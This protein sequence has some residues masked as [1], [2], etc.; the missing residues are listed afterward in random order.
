MTVIRLYQ[1]S[2]NPA[3]TNSERNWNKGKHIPA[4]GLFRIIQIISLM[5]TKV[6]LCEGMHIHVQMSFSSFL[7]FQSLKFSGID[8]VKDFS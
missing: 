7:A 8:R 2:L 5:T 1:Q 6:V 3:V 4:I